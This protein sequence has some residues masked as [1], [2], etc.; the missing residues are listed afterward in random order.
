MAYNFIEIIL[1]A[2]PILSG[3]TVGYII[4]HFMK[5]RWKENIDK[6]INQRK[7]ISELLNSE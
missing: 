3:L 7:E 5:K 2:T 4:V 6:D 1:Y